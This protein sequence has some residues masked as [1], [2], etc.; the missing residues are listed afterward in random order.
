MGLA[1]S[2]KVQSDGARL[3]I[4]LRLL[5]PFEPATRDKIEPKAGLQTTKGDWEKFSFASYSKLRLWRQLLRKNSH[6]PNES[7]ARLAACSTILVEFNRET[8]ARLSIENCFLR[9]A[10]A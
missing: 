1:S 5:N 7:E 4:V 3:Q 2:I 8:G 9:C 6:S 10:L